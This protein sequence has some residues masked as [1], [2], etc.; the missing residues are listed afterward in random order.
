V[1]Q[2]LLDGK[3]VG[4]FERS[5]PRKLPLPSLSTSSGEVRWDFLQFLL[6]E[7]NVN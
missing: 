2:V 1:I 6:S 7:W 5:N 4:F 3:I